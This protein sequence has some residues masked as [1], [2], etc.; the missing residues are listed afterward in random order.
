M[1]LT[2]SGYNIIVAI[3]L[4]PMILFDF[5]ANTIYTGRESEVYYF[6]TMLDGLLLLYALYQAF[7][8]D[9]ASVATAKAREASHTDSVV[10]FEKVGALEYIYC[11]ILVIYAAGNWWSLFQMNSN[12]TGLISI[13]TL[14]WS[15]LSLIVGLLSAVQF[16]H[17]KSG[18]IVQLQHKIVA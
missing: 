9:T 17:L 12:S 18:A 16:A 8:S 6:K 4:A 1:K 11:A 5:V 10:S 7:T 3:W 13:A 15:F 2:H 14:V